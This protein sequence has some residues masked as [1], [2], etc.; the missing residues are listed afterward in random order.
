MKQTT[1]SC[2]DIS[3]ICKN[4][5]CKFK[6]F[7]RLAN[8]KEYIYFY[9]HNNK[10]RK[11]GI[12]IAFY[13]NPYVIILQ[14]PEKC[15]IKS[16]MK[17]KHNYKKVYKGNAVVIWDKTYY[18][19]KTQVILKDETNYKLIDTN[20]DNNIISKITK[21]CKIYNKSLTKKEKDFLTNYISITSNFYGLPKVHKSKLIK[22]RRRNTKIWIYRYPEPQ[23]PQF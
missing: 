23:W 4:Y 16:H 10:K 20:I 7:W 21:F 9:K 13:Q 6:V 15:T 1:H 14:A 19:S 5:W 17:W 11:P 3:Q 8:K 2:L 22:K 18:E 12:V